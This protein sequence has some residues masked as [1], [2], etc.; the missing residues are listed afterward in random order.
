MTG[1]L[2]ARAAMAV[3]AGVLTMG[4]AL[5]GAAATQDQAS[6]SGPEHFTAFA[7]AMG[8]PGR[9]GANTVDIQIE[10]WSTDEDRDK[11]LT[12]LREQGQDK[13][14]SVLQSLPR[15]GFI[16]TPESIGYDLH[17]ARKHQMGGSERVIIATD[18]RIGFWEAANR[19]RSIDYPFSLIELRIGSN[20]KGEGKL[21][22]ATKITTENDGKTIVLENY[23]SQPVMLNNVTREKKT[24]SD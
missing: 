4:G 3:L 19:P 6:S 11:L 21:S 23:Q 9:T 10:R 1:S 5:S 7:V 24:N 16:R 13:M 12:A 14:L 8:T 20:G 15:V 18:R 2:I 22:I 17:F